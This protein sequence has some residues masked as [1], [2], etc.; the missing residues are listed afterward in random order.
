MAKGKCSSIK[1]PKARKAC[2]KRSG[3]V[4]AKGPKKKETQKHYN[5]VEK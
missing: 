4:G 5:P 1:D 3:A 2:E